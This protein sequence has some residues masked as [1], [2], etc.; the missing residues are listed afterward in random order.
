[1][2][3]LVSL[4]LQ[5]SFNN[6]GRSSLPLSTL[7]RNLQ[8]TE[9]LEKVGNKTRMKYCMEEAGK[10]VSV[11]NI[12]FVV[13]VDSRKDNVFMSNVRGDL[14]LRRY[15]NAGNGMPDLDA[16]KVDLLHK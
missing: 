2:R 16:D 11:G 8:H 15:T 12:Y 4:E 13:G 5:A 7:I 3:D 10:A 9:E 14:R 6:V 1:M